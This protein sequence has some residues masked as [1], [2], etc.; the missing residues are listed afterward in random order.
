MLDAMLEA[1]GDAVSLVL[2]LEVRRA[3]HK[4]LPRQAVHTPASLGD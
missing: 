3:P 2:A 1:S 4:A